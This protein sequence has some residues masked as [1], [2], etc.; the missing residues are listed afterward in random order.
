MQQIYQSLISI[1][2]HKRQK[3]LNTERWKTNFLD[4]KLVF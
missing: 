3:K 4:E 2:E 1:K